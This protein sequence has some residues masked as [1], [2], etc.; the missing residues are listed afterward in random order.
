[1]YIIYLPHDYCWT[2]FGQIDIWLGSTSTR[3]SLKINLIGQ[4]MALIEGTF[5]NAFEP[6]FLKNLKFIFL[7]KFNIVCIF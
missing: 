5:G 2:H 6:V 7:L 3:R 4:P 1:M